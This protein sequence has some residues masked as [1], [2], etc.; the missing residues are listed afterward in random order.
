MEENKGQKQVGNSEILQKK[1]SLNNRKSREEKSK[2]AV[3]ATR[4]ANQLKEMLK[5]PNN[6]FGLAQLFKRFVLIEE[7]F[8]KEECAKLAHQFTEQLE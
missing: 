1:V 2:V 4:N 8:Q 3:R 6:N 5:T 7:T